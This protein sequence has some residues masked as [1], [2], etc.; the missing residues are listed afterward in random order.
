MI[1]DM[2]RQH[3]SVLQEKNSELRWMTK[4]KFQKRGDRIQKISRN[5]IKNDWRD[6]DIQIGK[7][8]RDRGHSMTQQG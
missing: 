2:K 5:K 4:R 7:N 8:T 3:T 6:I 1:D